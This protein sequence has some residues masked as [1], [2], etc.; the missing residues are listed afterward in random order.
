M[1]LRTPFS[2]RVSRITR[3][4]LRLTFAF[5]LA[6]L[7]APATGGTGEV[8]VKDDFRGGL[9]AWDAPAEWKAENGVLHL[10]GGGIRLLKRGKDWRNYSVEFDARVR[11]H[12]VAL[13]YRAADRDH[14]YFTQLTTSDNPW[15]ANALRHHLWK[16]GKSLKIESS[17][18]H[19]TIEPGKWYRLRVDVYDSEAD[20]YI[21]GQWVDTW[22]RDDF[23]RGTIGFRAFAQEQ[24][25][26]RNLVVRRLA[27][28][29]SRPD[30]FARF[31]IEAEPEPSPDPLVSPPWIAHWIWS[32]GEPRELERYF[33]KTIE[34][35]E[36]PESAH[37]AIT[38][39]NAYELYV[40]GRLVAKDDEWYSLEEL[41]VTTR[42]H[43][44]R[45][46]VAVKV[47]NE[48]PGAAGLLLQGDICLPNHQHV[49]FYSDTAWRVAK[50]AP[51]SWEAV[52]FDDSAWP[53]AQS[54]GKHPCR[55]WGEARSTWRLSY[56]GPRRRMRLDE[57]HVEPFIR[58][59]EPLRL[60]LTVTALEE[61]PSN[62][63]FI[64]ELAMGD[65]RPWRAGV[66]YP[67]PPAD[68]WPVGAELGMRLGIKVELNPLAIELPHCFFL[69]PGRYDVY[70]RPTAAR[71]ESREDA[72]IG[73]VVLEPRHY[74]PRRAGLLDPEKARARA[75]TLVDAK[76]NKH[77]WRLT[78]RGTV[79]FDGE[80]MVPVGGSDGVYYCLV[81]ARGPLSTP[82]AELRSLETLR[83]LARHGMNELPVRCRL[84]DTIDCVKADRFYSDDLGRGGRSRVLTINGRKYRV[85]SARKAT[86]YFAL[87]AFVRHR[88][89]PHLFVF[90]TPNDIER[91]TFIRIQPPWDNVGGGVYTGREYLLDGKPH[92]QMFLFYPRQKAFR[93]TVSRMPCEQDLRPESGAAVS[94]VWILEIVDKLLDRAPDMYTNH[95][96]E[97]R[98]IGLSYSRPSHMYSLYGRDA[99]RDPAHHRL[100][101]LRFLEYLRFV[102]MNH[103]EFNAIDGA[104]T[105]ERAYYP[106]AIFPQAGR[107]DLFGD[108]LPLADRA[109]FSVIPCVTSLAFDVPKFDRAPWITRETFQLDRD[110]ETIRE[111]FRGRGNANGAPDPLRPEVQDVL[112][113]CL[114]EMGRACRSHRSVVGLAFRVN[115]KIG[116]CYTGYSQREQSQWAGY[117]RWDIAQFSRDT[118]I[119][120]PDVRPTP[121]GWL[122]ARCWREWIDWRCRRTRDFWLRARR[123]VRSARRDWDL[124]VKTDLPSESPGRNIN[125][126]GG[127]PPR[128]LLRH[129]GYDPALFS[130]H[131]DIVVQQGFFLAG[132]R[133]FESFAADAPQKQNIW[134]WRTFNYIPYLAQLYKTREPGSV[135]FY[136]N[137]WEELGI[138]KDGEFGTDFWG[139]ATGYPIGRYY[140]EP[141]THAL[142]AANPRDMVLFSWERGSFGREHDLRA[143]C[144]CFRALPYRKPRPYKGMLWERLYRSWYPESD[145]RSKRHRSL[146]REGDLWVRWF[147]DRLA[148]LNDSPHT[149]LVRVRWTGRIRRGRRLV[150]LATMRTLVDARER[151]V[152][153]PDVTIRLR[154]FELHTLLVLPRAAPYLER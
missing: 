110:G 3:H 22:R 49:P 154:P 17:P 85:T 104:D 15:K 1:V 145:R 56:H 25:S 143:F 31:R 47:R 52:W 72:W 99:R 66:V 112:F 23:P 27:E 38:A 141:L 61:F 9:G 78:E 133:Y 45:N 119:K 2:F 93:F 139:A 97:Q 69:V 77:R 14:C 53:R 123:I 75:G 115:G 153:W 42:F 29:P 136:N 140:F 86:S 150:D 109:G 100:A 134:A 106:S 71:Y 124:Y 151:S 125:W 4:A 50:T 74:D 126:P 7:F 149:R 131:R 59:G 30:P 48:A 137:Y 57:A 28:K 65:E 55:P 96:G 39:D 64:I 121:Y 80:E 118:G 24:S 128:E 113:R 58:P 73:S 130:R 132:D 117:S 8:L 90:E 12:C 116:T 20:F 41:D 46:I 122:R 147:G 105:T 88:Y 44:G 87:S 35:S 83:N 114:R 127:T 92:K 148:V 144:R 152:R 142:R 108:L 101:L 6:S 33:R 43:K 60:R 79:R 120:V 16:G 70:L 129:H 40:N 13:V 68:E 67:V 32:P 63:P 103:I 94:R 34:L 91:Y 84:V 18:L 51:K 82:L 107:L 95:G 135:E 89:K 37:L 76:G 36:R 111:F 19:L 146:L 62:F 21:D 26:V 98:R 81:E 5:A 102:G 10:N 54:Q 138:W 11:S